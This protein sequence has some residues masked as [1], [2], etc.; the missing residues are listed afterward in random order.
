MF[1]KQVNTSNIKNIL[2]ELFG[3]NLIRGR[4]VFCRSLIKAQTTSPIFSSVYAALMAVVN[5]KLPMVGELLVH[6]CI[7][8]FKR[9]YKRNDKRLLLCSAQFIAH[10]VNQQ[11]VTEVLALEI[12][13]L[14]LEDVC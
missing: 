2:P 13:T 5:T 1:M 9:A 10:L 12:L 3:E 6:R 4:G 7:A 8:Q 14:L 11:V